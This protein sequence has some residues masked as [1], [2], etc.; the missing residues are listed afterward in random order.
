MS[1]N[2]WLQRNFSPWKP[3]LSPTRFI[4][5]PVHA[6]PPQVPSSSSQG[7]TI[8]QED[9]SQAYSTQLPPMSMSL[10]W[11]GDSV[12]SR[13]LLSQG[14]K[15][16]ITKLRGLLW[17]DT[18]SR[19]GYHQLVIIEK[20]WLPQ[21]VHTTLKEAGNY[22]G[23]CWECCRIPEKLP[24][25]PSALSLVY[26]LQDT[27]HSTQFLKS[28]NSGNTSQLLLGKPGPRTQQEQEESMVHTLFS[29]QH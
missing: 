2:L 9:D 26:S 5:T 22:L 8:C 10:G 1:I 29:S 16:S 14:V 19:S 15:P 3:S 20:L 6:A 23:C 12:R 24:Q 18:Y 11:D 7:Q 27:N 4:D 13:K 28:V 17:R 21:G 25:S